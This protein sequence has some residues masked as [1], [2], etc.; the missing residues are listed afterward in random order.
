MWRRF[1]EDL[2][3]A[4]SSDFGVGDLLKMY[5]YFGACRRKNMF[6]RE[7]LVLETC[8]IRWR[9]VNEQNTN[10]HSIF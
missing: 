5:E 7:D 3:A 6:F 2:V 4:T 10:T 9:C 8:Q 1:L